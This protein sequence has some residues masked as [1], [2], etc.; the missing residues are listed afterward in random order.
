MA[1]AK[2]SFISNATC[3]NIMA[4]INVIVSIIGAIYILFNFG[5]VKVESEYVGDYITTN[6]YGIAGAI[7]MLIAS[8]TIFFLLK[9][10]VDIYRK[11]GGIE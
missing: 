10:I 3:L 4:Y 1:K 2:K 7:A 6:S 11:V 8:F 9:T 5:I